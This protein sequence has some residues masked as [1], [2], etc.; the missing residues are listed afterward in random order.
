MD[1]GHKILVWWTRG[2]QRLQDDSML[3][4]S[5][6]F[7]RTLVMPSLHYRPEF[8]PLYK[9]QILFKNVKNWGKGGIREL[10]AIK[11]YMII[12]SAKIL[13]LWLLLCLHSL[14]KN[15]QMSTC[16][17]TKTYKHDRVK[18]SQRL[19]SNRCPSHHSPEWVF[20]AAERQPARCVMNYQF[21]GQ[22]RDFKNTYQHVFLGNSVMIVTYRMLHLSTPVLDFVHF[23]FMDILIGA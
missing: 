9:S 23:S 15:V 18:N 4:Q 21:Q 3:I 5:Y 7:G 6:N 1:Y 8:K 10:Q 14:M 16:T 13:F 22:R 2:L 17:L 19:W 11:I 20:H 12:L